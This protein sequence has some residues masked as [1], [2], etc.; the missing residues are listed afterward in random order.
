[1]YFPETRRQLTVRTESLHPDRQIGVD[2]ALVGL[3]HKMLDLQRNGGR[4]CELRKL[5]G[6][7][8]LYTDRRKC[9]GI[10][11]LNVCLETKLFL[12][13]VLLRHEKESD[14]VLFLKMNLTLYKIVHNCQS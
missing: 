13:M 10:I 2:E 3:L 12:D 9:C 8:K 1:M 14:M 7:I 11:F 4:L 6:E 5:L